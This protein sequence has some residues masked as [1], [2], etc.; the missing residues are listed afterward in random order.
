M[1]TLRTKLEIPSRDAL[2]GFARAS[3]TLIAAGGIILLNGPL[4]AGKT[5][6]VQAWAH[7]LGVTD[8]VTSPTFDLLHTYQSGDPI[9]YH[10][11][12]YR[13]DTAKDWEV[14]DLPDAGQAHTLIIVEWGL[15]I[16]AQH[17]NR[18]EIDIARESGEERVLVMEAFGTAWLQ[19][20]EIWMKEQGRGL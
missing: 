5:T 16:A 18:L 15:A 4:G 12:G 10:V 3:R 11:D 13:L 20:L 7:E 17:P 14:L 19:R 8:E 6:L 2:L 1:T 9:I